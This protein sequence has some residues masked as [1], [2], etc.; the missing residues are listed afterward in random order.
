MDDFKPT[1]IWAIIGWL[2]GAGVPMIIQPPADFLTPLQAPLGY[3]LVFF[4]IGAMIFLYHKGRS[5]TKAKDIVS[6]VKEAKVT[7]GLWHTGATSILDRGVITPGK[8]TSIK[9]V[10]LLKPD[11]NT[12]EFKFLTRF[13]GRDREAEQK[14]HI[15]ETNSLIDLL[16]EAKIPYRCYSEYLLFTFTIFDKKPTEKER[17]EDIPSSKDAYV[18]V[19]P[20]E[21]KRRL[22]P[23]RKWV[24]RNKG[25]DKDQFE[26]YLQLYKE[27]WQLGEIDCETTKNE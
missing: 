12:P 21:P 15:D 4:A 20:V 18:V 22:R 8:P 14:R 19:Q 9:R 10:L 27:I 11:P 2:G 7:W 5:E 13:A 16:H 24:V 1:V 23:Y 3:G 17:G 25:K 6:A 26:A